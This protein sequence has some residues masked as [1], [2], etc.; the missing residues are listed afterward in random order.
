MWRLH[1]HEVVLDATPPDSPPLRASTPILVT[2][3]PTAPSTPSLL[4][5]SV[6]QDDLLGISNLL[7]S[8]LTFELQ[9]SLELSAR[10]FP[11]HE[12][13]IASEAGDDTVSSTE[14]NSVLSE[15]S[16]HMVADS[17]AGANTTL[18]KAVHS[19]PRG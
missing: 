11:Q 18:R 15:N 19:L 12:P 4:S 17:N 7:G 13:R 8:S 6:E 2:P 16:Y 1:G 10:V 5:F 3:E 9:S 14:Q